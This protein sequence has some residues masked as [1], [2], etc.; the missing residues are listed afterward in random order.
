MILE[1]KWNLF[2]VRLDLRYFESS[3]AVFLIIYNIMLPIDVYH[4]LIVTFTRESLC[5]KTLHGF[6]FCKPVTNLSEPINLNP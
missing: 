2:W 3:P 6:R 4:K 5:V 1:P